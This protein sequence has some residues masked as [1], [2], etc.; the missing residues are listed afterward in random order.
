MGDWKGGVRDVKGEAEGKDL[1][2]N[3]RI[4]ISLWSNG[5]P[6]VKQETTKWIISDVH[7]CSSEANYKS[8]ESVL[9]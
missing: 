1:T 5:S 8:G 2:W 7:V 6:E 3:T 4:T 9:G